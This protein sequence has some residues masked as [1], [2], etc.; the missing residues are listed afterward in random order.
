MSNTFYNNYLYT[1]LPAQKIPESEKTEEWRQRCVTAI[2]SMGNN[3]M[4]NGR[5]TWSHKQVNYDLV[6]SIIDE[7]DFELVLNPYGLKEKPGKQP[8]KLRALNLVTSKINLLKGEEMLRPFK[9][10]VLGVNGEVLNEREQMRKD[11]LLQAVQQSLAKELGVSL[12]PQVDP[13]TGEQIPPP[14]FQTV[15]KHLKD[16]FK[17]IRE[18][19]GNH[20]LQYLIH[21]EKLKLRFNEGWEHALISAEEIYYIGISNGEVRIRV[22]NPLN[23]EFDR[24]PDNPSI[25]DGDWFKE[26]RW[27]SKGQIMDEY[28]DLLSPEQLDVLD[29]YG[30]KAGLSNQMFPGYGYTQDDVNFYG[31]SRFSNTHF[32]VSHVVWRSLKEVVFLSYP[33]ENGEI[34]ESIVDSTFKL[35]PALK[36][37][38]FKAERR[39]IE[40]IW[41]GTKIGQDIF[42]GMEPVPNQI[43]NMD[44][45]Y[46]APLPYVGR[47]YNST[48]SAQ[49]SFVD[50][51]KRHQYLYIITWFRL[52]AEIAKAKGKKMVFDIAQLPKS[53]GFD[54]EKWMY[55]F[56]NVGLAVINSFEEG[57]DKFQGQVSHFNQFQAI[58]MTISQSIAQYINI[59]D[60][61]E[62]T[63]NKIVGITPQREGSIHQSE[64]VGGVERS[65]ANSS[66]ITE[67]WFY[68]HNEVKREVLTHALECAKFAFPKSKK[69]VNV[70][71]GA[72]QIFID[73]DMEKFADSDYSVFVTDSSREHNIFQKLEALANQALSSGVATYSDIVKLYKAN[74]ISEF[75][76][77]IE[78]AEEKRQQQQSQQQQVQQ[79]MQ[80]Q[81]LEAQAQEKAADRQ[82]Q[83]E[84]NQLDRENKIREAVIKA[85]SFDTDTNDSGDLEAIKYGELSLKQMDSDRKHQQEASKLQ[86][87]SI[88]KGKDRALKE[89]EIASKERIEKLKAQTALKNKVTGEK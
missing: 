23:C 34:Q 11:L 64:T 22:C 44:N 63:V 2:C 43:R 84:Q 31:K 26:D 57:K 15:E 20:I 28:G 83:A 73:L 67:P 13:Q 62:D 46:H 40:D 69:I 56:D 17:D 41:H 19:W 42:L 50:L 85:T 88:E 35:T 5:S 80:Q 66:L 7:K 51:I 8:A 70:I 55:F 4:S 16:S 89:K 38:G 86:H 65:I 18:Q 25:Q 48:N 3:R 60:K 21:K 24:N 39:W 54:L 59:M 71:D 47:V 12:E 75:S 10:F 82:F 29:K 27:M 61:I 77:L 81:T 87:D 32:L 72:E 9:H 6:N 58:D 37:M 68:I 52:E 14:T 79:Q 53:E 36:Q 33:D 45:P 78:E 76:H 1:T 49:T 30:T 74:S